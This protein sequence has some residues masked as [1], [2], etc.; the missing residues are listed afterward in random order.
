MGLEDNP[1]LLGFGLFSGANLLLVLGRLSGNVMSE[2]LFERKH[3]DFDRISRIYPT[4][5]SRISRAKTS[6]ER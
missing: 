2:F 4:Q 3:L 1:F 5:I 6:T